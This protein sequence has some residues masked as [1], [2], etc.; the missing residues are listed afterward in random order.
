LIIALFALPTLICVALI[1]PILW[2]ALTETFILPRL[3][4]QQCAVVK[5]SAAR[6]SCYDHVTAQNSPRFSAQR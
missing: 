6:L 5:D 4:F 2:T 1:A 3:T